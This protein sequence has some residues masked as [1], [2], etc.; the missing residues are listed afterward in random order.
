VSRYL[1]SEL[2]VLKQDAMQTVVNLEEIWSDG[3]A[4]ESDDPLAIGIAVELECGEN[5]FKGTVVSATQHEF[6]WWIELSFSPETPWNPEIFRPGHMVDPETL[7][8]E[9]VP[10]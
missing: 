4:L 9:K 5:R 1:C 2:V 10:D 3:A 8:G 7:K 6:G